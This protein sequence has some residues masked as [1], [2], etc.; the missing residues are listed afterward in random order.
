LI[1]AIVRDV[2]DRKL[3]ENH[4]IETLDR[5]EFFV[6]LMGHDLCNINQAVTGTLE[7]V[8]YENE[9][10][11]ATIE[12]VSEA[13]KQVERASQLIRSVRKLTTILQRT[14]IEP[15]FR[16][17]VIDVKR[18][19]IE[20]DIRIKTNIEPRIFEVTADNYLYD[21]FY[22]LLQN[23]IKFDRNQIVNLDVT[24]LHA[25]ENIRISIADH[26]KGI[27]DKTK[28]LLF[29][30][31]SKRKEGFWGTGIGLTLVKQII[32]R[33]EGRAWIEDRV[34]GDH[35]QGAKFVFELRPA[36]A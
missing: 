8:L 4:L 20:K 21:V 7:L 28:A 17:A 14:D 19:F 25:E 12:S 13:M 26:G 23:S 11:K 10:S 24:A 27:P 2:T 1:Q 22:N 29:A 35:T 30:R 33:Y 16:N 32:E 15:L 18:D 36:N 3:A 5:A 34:R 6:D 31:I 9:Q